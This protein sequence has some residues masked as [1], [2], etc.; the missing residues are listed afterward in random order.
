M[1]ITSAIDQLDE[2]DG[3]PVFQVNAWQIRAV[4]Y[5]NQGD[6]KRATESKKHV[7]M[8]QIQRSPSQAFESAYLRSEVISYA[9]ADDLI[10]VKQTIDR[11]EKIAE[12]FERWKPI[13]HYAVGEYQRI[14]GD[15][16][17]ALVEFDKAL[18]LTEAGHHVMW[19]VLA[20]SYLKTLLGQ[21]HYEEVKEQGQKMLKDAEEAGIDY[22]IHLI[23][24]PVALAQAHLGEHQI[25]VD[26]LDAI[27]DQLTKLGITG[28]NLGFV[29]ENRARIAILMDDD[30]NYQIHARRCYKQ[31]NVGHN[32][33]LTARY[34][35][36]TQE[37]QHMRLGISPDPEHPTV[38]S[39]PSAQFLSSLIQSKMRLCS[40]T[41]ER[42]QGALELIID[43]Y[44]CSGGFL[45]TMQGNGPVLS[46]TSG[47]YPLLEDI[48]ILVNDHLSAE[49]DETNNITITASGNTLASGFS[50]RLGPQGESFR[51]LLLG[52]P[53]DDGYVITGLAILVIKDDQPFIFRRDISEE[54]SRTLAKSGDVVPVYAAS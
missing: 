43:H 21:E 45:Y 19:P 54:I 50:G 32:P 36:L 2:L 28:L 26:S 17:K 51:P 18:H 6:Y 41:K 49:L 42:L 40:G 23:I 22:G 33:A 44:N 16:Q 29:H 35:K 46:G 3:D 31:Y 12:R 13:Y 9:H 8:L 24:M 27:V 1:G 48:E 34:Q 20:E 52:H 14:R 7:E 38:S 11:I 4:Y 39:T 53:S 47:E 5:L 30:V 15:Y 25:A 10:G 37:A